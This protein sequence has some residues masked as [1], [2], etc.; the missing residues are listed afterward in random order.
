MP[1]STLTLYGL[2]D[3][4]RTKYHQ[5]HRVSNTRDRLIVVSDTDVN[6]ITILDNDFFLMFSDNKLVLN[7]LPNL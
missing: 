5:K 1:K 7:H 6:I 4:S 2:Y 3:I